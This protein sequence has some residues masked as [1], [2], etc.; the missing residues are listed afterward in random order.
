ML[1]PI[2]FLL[3]TFFFQAAM[4]SVGA[5]GP[6]I[7][8]VQ[9]LRVEPDQ[10][11]LT[12]SGSRQQ[13]LVTAN[14][15]GDNVFDAAAVVEFDVEDDTVAV[16]SGGL[17]KPVG[18]GSTIVRVRA[19]DLEHGV[20]VTVSKFEKRSPVQFATEVLAALTK[21]GCNMGA[22]HGSP[23]G[24]AGFRLSLRGYDPELDL[25][26][27]RNELFSRRANLLDPEDSLLLRKPLMD[28]SHGGGRR[29]Q[30]GDEPHA[31][32]LQWISEGM[33]SGP[34]ESPTL[35]CIEVIPKT[36]V[37]RNGMDRQQ[38]IVN[39]HFSDGSVRDVTGLTVFDSS[40]KDIATVSDSGVVERRGRGEVT[41]LA[42]YLER[43]ATA[44]V[45]FLTERPDFEWPEPLIAGEIDRL[46]FVK[47]KQLQIAPSKLCTDAE[48]LRRATLDLT[49]RLPT[50]DE[51]AALEICSE[52]SL[53][54]D[55]V[56]RLLQSDDYATFWSMK[57]GDLLRCNS[58]RLTESGVHKFRRWLF[59]CVRDDRPLN[60]FVVDLLTATG[61]VLQ[62][63]AANFWRTCQNE[64]E[65]A[66][67]TAQL[68]LGI[69]IQCAKCH[70]HPFERWTQDD[71]YGIAAA[72]RRVGRKL[73]PLPDD[74]IVYLQNSG[75]V[76]QPRTQQTMKVRLLMKG[77]VDVPSEQDR[78]RVF[79]DWLVDDSNPFFAR[80]VANRIW[81]H[82]M[83][84][85]IVEPVDDFR[86]SNPPSIPE[87]L[88]WLAAELRRGDYSAKHL[89]RT[90]MISRVY[91]L[92]AESGQL[93]ADDDRYFSHHHARMLTA[94]QLLDAVCDVTGVAETYGAMPAGFRAVQLVDPPK[95][96]SFLQVFG[97]PARE[98]PCECERSTESNLSQALQLINGSTVH[99]KIRSENGRLH[100]WIDAGKSDEEI[101][102]LLYLTSVS[103]PPTKSELQTSLAHIA[104]AASRSQG[105]EDLVWGMINSREFVFQH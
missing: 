62:N 35:E 65:A 97:Q 94:E 8:S 11:H 77:E 21:A 25:R 4:L 102:R 17:L 18:N 42:R 66:E 13:L 98:L 28:V 73:G 95:D 36:R 90:I 3:V 6:G 10:I 37:I 22:C 63:P 80:S 29:L 43:M 26:T 14:P 83:G 15:S 41:V 70:N 32:L 50:L 104:M 67:T 91:Q 101:V 27:L 86:D 88:D 84:R 71:Y 46:V 19:G 89:I 56:D 74:Q 105:L 99:D 9:S 64:L 59:A 55:L 7:A 5:V 12:G 60:Q 51:V 33:R 48:F 76:T 31:V 49:G 85:G 38:L 103:R 1:R 69:R 23:S 39:G 52:E 61:S 34:A 57:W 20:L 87:L 79:A 47:L 82:L 40:S 100:A 30:R 78:R 2:L 45:T 92:S 24:K 68:F 96:H 81:G 53:R 44:H 72:F 75:E 54:A 58:K 93:N 16:V